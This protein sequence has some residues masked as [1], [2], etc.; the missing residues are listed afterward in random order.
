[1]KS[2][3]KG[4]RFVENVRR[5]FGLGGFYFKLFNHVNNMAYGKLRIMGV[6]GN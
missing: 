1:V 6:K 2:G 4:R 5:F 3:R